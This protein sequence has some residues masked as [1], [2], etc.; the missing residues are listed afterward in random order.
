M[1]RR[2]IRPAD[3]AAALFDVLPTYARPARPAP[4]PTPEAS[5]LLLLDTYEEP[6]QHPR[7]A[8]QQA[9]GPAPCWSAMTPRQFGHPQTALQS[10]LFAAEQDGRRGTSELF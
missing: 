10:G 4:G 1:P 5:A 3:Q 8:E 2:R 7:P 6:V 9:A